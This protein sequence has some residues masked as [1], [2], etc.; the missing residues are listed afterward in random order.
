[1]RDIGACP[2]DF[3]IHPFHS[4][5]QSRGQNGDVRASGEVMATI[6]T[7]TRYVMEISSSNTFP[8]PL[9]PISRPFLPFPLPPFRQHNPS[10]LFHRSPSSLSL[11]SVLPTA[12]LPPSRR[13]G[14]FVQIP[15]ALLLG[16]LNAPTGCAVFRVHLPRTQF[17]GTTDT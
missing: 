9:P 16:D 14:P 3:F 7:Y 6:R 1:M 5:R 2:F 12:P 15:R 4:S 8:L 13:T 11:F 17:N 10:S